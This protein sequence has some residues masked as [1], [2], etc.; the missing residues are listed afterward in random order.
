[1]AQLHGVARL[2][3]GVG[4]RAHFVTGLH[5][6]GGENVAALAIGVLDQR[7]VAGA[8]RIVLETFNHALDAVLVA[9]EIDE[10]VLVVRA[11]ALMARGDAAHVVATGMARLLDDQR[12]VRAALPQVRLVE[13]DDKPRARRSRLHFDDW[14]I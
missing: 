10:P 12:L 8:V 2:D 14:H 5:A 13:L 7:D 3:R 11:A 6:L 1:V 9:L 4:A